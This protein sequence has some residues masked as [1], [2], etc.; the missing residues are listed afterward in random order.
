MYSV[1][2]PPVAI[3]VPKNTKRLPRINI[4]VRVSPRNIAF[5]TNAKTGVK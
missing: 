4:I 1:V 3:N 2:F 5:I